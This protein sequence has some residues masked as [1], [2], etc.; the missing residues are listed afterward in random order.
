MSPKIRQM[1]RLL[2]CTPWCHS[3]AS[4]QLPR[5]ASRRVQLV[6]ILRWCSR[7]SLQTFGRAT[8]SFPSSHCS[9]PWYLLSWLRYIPPML[10][11]TVSRSPRLYTCLQ[12]SRHEPGRPSSPRFSGVTSTQ[13]TSWK[14]FATSLS[15]MTSF[16]VSVELFHFRITASFIVGPELCPYYYVALLPTRLQTMCLLHSPF[17]V[18][19]CSPYFECASASEPNAHAPG[20]LPSPINPNLA[21]SLWSSYSD[22]LSL[23][24]PYYACTAYPCTH[25]FI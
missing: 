24:V 23:L 22:R 11:R 2:M 16:L 25:A 4:L 10:S 3:T 17:Q 5:P 12:T 8:C 18:P 1:G 19:S 6:C 7:I 20:P 15:I 14:G 13:T 21:T 9:P